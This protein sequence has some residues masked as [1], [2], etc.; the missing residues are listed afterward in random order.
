MSTDIEIAEFLGSSART[1]ARAGKTKAFQRALTQGR[2]LAKLDP[3]PRAVPS[4]AVRQHDNAD[5]YRQSA[6]RAVE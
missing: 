2:N 1:V 6:F 4:G 3:S 5:F